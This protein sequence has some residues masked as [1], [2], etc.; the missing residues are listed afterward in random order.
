MKQYNEAARLDPTDWH[1]PLFDWA[2][3]CSSKAA[4]RKPFCISVKRYKWTR[5]I[6]NVL[7]YLAQVLASDENPRIRDGNAA[8]A[9]AAKANDLT[10]DVQPAMFDALAM[11][12]AE[13]RPVHKRPARPRPMP[14]NSPPLTT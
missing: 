11:A 6:L 1:V 2:R 10:G 13:T 5:T 12:Y 14:S 7:T 4:T 9:M 8:L 3:R